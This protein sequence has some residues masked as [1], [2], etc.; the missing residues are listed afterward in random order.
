MSQLPHTVLP[1]A[2]AA[3][4]DQASGAKVKRKQQVVLEMFFSLRSKHDAET[5]MCQ[6]LHT[7]GGDVSRLWSPW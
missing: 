2:A 1:Q 5:N 3:N 4:E 7:D 6:R